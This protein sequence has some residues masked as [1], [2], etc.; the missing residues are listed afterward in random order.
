MQRGFSGS[1]R[2]N[3]AKFLALGIGVVCVIV[4]AVFLSGIGGSLSGSGSAAS[5]TGPAATPQTAGSS[6]S[7][8][9]AAATSIPEMSF[10][11]PTPVPV[12]GTGVFVRVN[13]FGGFT[14]KYSVNGTSQDVKSSGCRIYEIADPAGTVSASFTKAEN[15]AKQNIT[16]E[17]WKGGKLLGSNLT[18]AP[19]GT[20]TVSAAV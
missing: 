17:I 6:E 18:Y 4:V 8:S 19:Y 14:G 5:G 10:T 15:S 2:R 9:H 16:V 12:P 13:Y 3:T 1:P 11:L 7:G 20:A